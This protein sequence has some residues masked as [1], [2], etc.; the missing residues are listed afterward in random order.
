V[1][2]QSTAGPFAM[3]L[4]PAYSSDGGVNFT[5]PNSA[6]GFARSGAD[7]TEWTQVFNSQTLNLT[8][9]TSYIFGGE[10]TR[11]SGAA[12]PTNHR[13]NTLVTLSPR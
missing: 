5:V 7:S 10:V 6:F 11:E 8:A 13:C 1:V 2:A 12:D 4:L 9:G 3:I